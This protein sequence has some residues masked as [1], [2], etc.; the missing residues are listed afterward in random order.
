MEVIL[1]ISLIA[2][3]AVASFKALGERNER[4][5]SSSEILGALKGRETSY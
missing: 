1:S 5:G 3:F 2:G 4:L